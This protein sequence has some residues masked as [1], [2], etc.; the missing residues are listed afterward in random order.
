MG[1]GTLWDN[2]ASPDSS[3]GY[4]VTIL[5]M[6]LFFF[7]YILNSITASIYTEEKKSWQREHDP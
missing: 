4:Y 2:S 1:Q 3:F 6:N 7:V 5:I